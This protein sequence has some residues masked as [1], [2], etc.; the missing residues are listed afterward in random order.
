MGKIIRWIL[1]C[2]FAVILLFSAYKLIAYFSENQTAEKSYEQA[3][4]LA[5]PQTEEPLSA[6]AVQPDSQK[7]EAD[8]GWGDAYAEYVRD[9]DLEKLQKKNSDVIAWIYLPDTTISYPVLQGADNDTYLHTTWDRKKNRAGSIFLEAANT[10]D[11]QDLNTI[12]YGHHMANGSMFADIT[13]FKKKSFLKKHPYV[14]IATEDGVRRYQIFAAYETPVESETYRVHFAGDAQ[15]QTALQYYQKFAANKDLALTAEDKILTL[16]T[17]IGDGT[18][19]TRW[20]VQAVL[21]DCWE[22]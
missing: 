4:V 17:C 16:S 9:V 2:V 1:I 6:D 18:Y 20:V 13:D 3:K 11:F 12:V 22:K 14:Y 15:K 10:P 21:T 5:L 8:S 19:E 7:P